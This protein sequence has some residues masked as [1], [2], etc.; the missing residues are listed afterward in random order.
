[1]AQGAAIA[2]PAGAGL[3]SVGYEAIVGGEPINYAGGTSLA[4]PIWAAIVA[5]MNQARR[6]AGQPRVGFVNPLLY[7]LA[8][9]AAGSAASPF[10]SITVGAGDVEMHVLDEAGRPT[11]YRLEGFSAES[12]WNPVTGLGVPHVRRLIDMSVRGTGRRRRTRR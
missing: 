1:M 7:E 3:A 11:S 10:R 8:R 5:C 2:N 12:G 6:A 9:S 4:A